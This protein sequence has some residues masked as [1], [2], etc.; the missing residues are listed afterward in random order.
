MELKLY[1]NNA[2]N[3]Q[4][5]EYFLVR[6]HTFGSKGTIEKR[7]NAGAKYELIIEG[8]TEASIDWM[9]NNFDPKK[10]APG[11]LI[12]GWKREYKSPPKVPRYRVQRNFDL[13]NFECA[14]LEEASKVFE[15]LA[16]DQK[17]FR[18]ILWEDDREIRRK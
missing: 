10:G 12:D 4:S 6:S 2:R 3:L 8:C 1:G 11:H 13:H 5:W 15:K 16:Q 14:S 7:T 18:L 17:T 9:I